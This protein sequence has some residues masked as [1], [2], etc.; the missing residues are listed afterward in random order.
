[1]N[2]RE[3]ITLLYL[4]LAGLC[5]TVSGLLLMADPVGTL[6]LMGV[7]TPLAEPLYMQWIG[8][9]VFSVGLSYFTPFIVRN[10]WEQVRGVLSV[11]LI[12]RIVIASFSGFSMLRGAL[13]PTWITVPLS[14]AAMGIIQIVLLRLLARREVAA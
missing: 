1:M 9:F 2:Q 14:D 4:L 3:K 10:R 11:T 13:D 7:A 6:T 12:V 5:D 8:A